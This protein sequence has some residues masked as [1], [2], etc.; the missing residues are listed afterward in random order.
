MLKNRRDVTLIESLERTLA[1]V[2][3]Q[4]RGGLSIEYAVSE[5]LL[6]RNLETI[7]TLATQRLL[8]L[9]Y[10]LE[11]SRTLEDNVSLKPKPI[12]TEMLDYIP[13]TFHEV[14]TIPSKELAHFNNS[15][16]DWINSQTVRELNEFLKIYLLELYEICVV[17]EHTKAPIRVR[18]FVDIKQTSKDFEKGGMKDRLR[19]LG[20]KFGFKLTHH[21]EILS[22]YNLRNVLSHSD[23]IV[24]KE[25]CNTDDE[26]QVSWPKNICKFKKKGRNEWVLY[27]KANR[28]FSAEMYDS[29]QINWLSKPEIR[30][31]KSQDQIKLSQKD[32]NDLVS[33]Y[34]Y[35]FNELHSK[36]VDVVK[37]QGFK[38]KPF[39]KYVTTFGSLQF[40]SPDELQGAA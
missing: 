7:Y 20:K 10:Y 36:L 4:H 22:L 25:F 2:P 26:L 27:E 8:H 33:F 35:V 11:W 16:A 15:F 21:Q 17:L 18:D 3:I 32:L 30:R 29:V 14:E 5:E 23:G 9:S 19:I 12:G 31:Y 40:V 38:V 39:E 28:P 34:L 37:K 6:G 24:T 1:M 13:A